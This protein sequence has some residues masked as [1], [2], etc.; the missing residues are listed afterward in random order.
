MSSTHFGYNIY[1]IC[2]IVNHTNSSSSKEEHTLKVI[3]I[4]NNFHESRKKTVKLYDRIP[5]KHMPLYLYDFVSIKVM[6]TIKKKISFLF[7]TQ[8]FSHDGKTFLIIKLIDNSHGISEVC[9]SINLRD[10]Y[11]WTIDLNKR[12]FNVKLLDELK[13]EIPGHPREFFSIK[14]LKDLLRLISN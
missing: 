13:C 1:E 3:N 10:S 4:I 2:F 8:L 7:N 11:N 6:E 14:D 12:K 5:P 9:I